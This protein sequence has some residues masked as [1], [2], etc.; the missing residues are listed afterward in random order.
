MR[1][2]S[3]SSPRLLPD[4]TPLENRLLAVLPDADYLRIQRHLELHHVE[5]GRTI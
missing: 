3:I 1:T 5:T 2:R 4:G